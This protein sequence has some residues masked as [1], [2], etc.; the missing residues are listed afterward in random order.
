MAVSGSYDV[1]EKNYRAIAAPVCLHFLPA[2]KPSDIPLED[3]KILLA[4]RLHDLI[5]EKLAVGSWQ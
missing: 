5:S 2:V 4:Q 1:F 3:R